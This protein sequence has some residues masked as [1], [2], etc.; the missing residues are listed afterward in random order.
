MTNA[1]GGPG[2]TKPPIFLRALRK[3]AEAGKVEAMAMLGKALQD[4]NE[5][6]LWLGR[7][8][9]AGHGV[10]AGLA[11]LRCLESGHKDQAVD[12][13]KKG[14]HVQD[15]ESL[16]HLGLM[17]WAGDG[18]PEDHLEAL[19]FL[20]RAHEA[21]H[22]GAGEA[23]Q[24]LHR[25]EGGARPEADEALQLLRT[26][27]RL[28]RPESMVE[29]GRA[30]MVGDKVGVNPG[31]AMELLEGAALQAYP[32]AHYELYR[33]HSQ[34]GAEFRNP[35][36]AELHLRLAME[37]GHPEAL[38]VAGVRLLRQ[39]PEQALPLLRRAAEL[40]LP[41]ALCALGEA[42]YE[43][44]GVSLNKLEA[45][46]WFRAAA[47]AGSREAAARAGKMLRKGDGVMANK[48]EAEEWE[49]LAGTYGGI[50]GKLGI[51]K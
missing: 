21:G 27:P 16:Y 13:F 31:R 15:P 2:E 19:A 51:K 5:A 12:W 8:F 7:A 30:L 25:E 34:G 43:G 24:K 32:D 20:Q 18:L 49:R 40:D 48:A 10:S 36:K 50:W 22:E 4:P 37:A 6:L 26:L 45:L 41:E 29:L 28:H 44:L 42:S 23:L 17:T 3:E 9:E 39:R 47:R 33:I 1:A 11:G 38:Q 14:A 46:R 35:D